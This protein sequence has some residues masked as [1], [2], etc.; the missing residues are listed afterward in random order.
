MSEEKKA[1]MVVESTPV[2]ADELKD[3]VM[4]YKNDGW[5]L[6]TMTAIDIDENS[7]EVLYTFDMDLKLENLRL[8][9]GQQDTVP[10]ISDIYFAA[11]LVENEIQ[12]QFGLCFKGLVLDFDRTLYKDDEVQ[13]FPFCKYTVTKA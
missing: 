9:C 7:I 2:T 5:R 6:L 13:T 10:S 12:D 3:K 8:T 1:P 11:F 4:K